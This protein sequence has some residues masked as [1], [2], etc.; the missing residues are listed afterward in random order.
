[1]IEG[2]SIFLA[3]LLVGTI[4]KKYRKKNVATPK[5]AI[6][7][8]GHGRSMHLDGKGKCG[9]LKRVEGT[10]N[11]SSHHIKCPCTIYE[12]PEPMPE[13]FAKELE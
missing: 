10:G 1:M 9:D 12:G 11:K 2:A 4:L 7:T 13:Y 5:G 6:C 3:G 8:C